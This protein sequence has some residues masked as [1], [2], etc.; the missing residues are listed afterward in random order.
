MRMYQLLL[1]APGTG[2][3]VHLVFAL[4][5]LT[6]VG[7]DEPQPAPAAMKLLQVEFTRARPYD[8]SAVGG[9]RGRGT[10][11][12]GGPAATAGNP[13]LLPPPPCSAGCCQKASHCMPAWAPCFPQVQAAR[14]K[15]SRAR[16]LTLTGLPLT[17]ACGAP[18]SMPRFHHWRPEQS[19]MG[20]TSTTSSLPHGF[21][22]K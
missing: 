2:S 8:C 5:A 18:P 10:G 13:L 21:A 3:K 22:P 19:V 9:A 6:S 20:Q 17:S 1:L 16:T 4:G 11:Q 7:A 14:L 12:V 15:S